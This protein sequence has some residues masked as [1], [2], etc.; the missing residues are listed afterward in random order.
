MRTIRVGFVVIATLWAF[1]GPGILS[2]A[3]P[4]ASAEIDR[5]LDR[6]YR[7]LGIQPAA[8]IPDEVFLRRIYLDVA[9]RIP[10][11]EE[12]RTFL[13][14]T[15]PGKRAQLIDELLESE[16]YVS[17]FFN[18]WADILRINDQV[19]N[20]RL[21]ST[22]WALWVKQALRGNMPY[23]QFVREMVSAE[24]VIWENG[25]VGYYQRDR[26]MPL[27]NMSNTVRIF[28]GTRLECAQ[29]HNHPFDTWKQID[30]YHM[31]AFSYGMNARNYD[32]PNRKA[33]T[34]YQREMARNASAKDKKN[35]NSKNAVKYRAARRVV[36]D[37]YNPIRYIASTQTERK[38][39]LP[40]D[41]QYDDFKPKAVVGPAAMFGEEIDPD[42]FDS[43][44]DAYADWM[45]SPDNPRFTLVIANRL[46]K[47][48][49]GRGLIEPVDELMEGTEAANPAL[50]EFLVR[51]M[52]EVDYDMKAFLRELYNTQIY[53]REASTEELLPGVVYHFPGPVLRRMSA[54]QIWDS[55]MTL[56]IP[57]PDYF[58]PTL[59]NRLA[60]VDQAKKIYENLEGRSREDFLDLVKK[61]TQIY[62]SNYLKTEELSRQYTKAREND[63]ADKVKQIGKEL[64]GLRNN[65]RRK[66][67]QLAGTDNRD[68]R[69][70]PEAL[71]SV[72][73][74]DGSQQI[75]MDEITTALPK[76]EKVQADRSL[77]K[78][79]QKRFYAEL[80]R[81]MAEWRKY[82][83]QLMRASELSSP[84]P[85]GHFV[86]EFGQS[87]REVIENAAYS[88]S[89]P[90]ALT[91]LNGPVAEALSN[92][93]S[94]LSKHL[95]DCGT[96]EEKAQTLYLAMLSRDP[97]REEMELL[98]S[99]I[100][101]HG[102][103]AYENIV[104]ALVNSQNFR[105]I[106]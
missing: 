102:E 106:Q 13:D 12:A 16:G 49:M 92:R 6:S 9:G 4:P 25:A 29:C 54:E 28:L 20:N 59:R 3:T 58:M 57:E 60:Q 32:S 55:L 50:M 7:E 38:V 96:A 62:S 81:D 5:I 105:F 19:N 93:N 34:D 15:E 42:N 82:A 99:E 23:D 65:A 84:A 100:E 27:D 88:A 98:T 11:V 56:T 89:V 48:V 86:R 39:Q 1:Q 87:D 47:R 79:Q 94:V 69:G 41:Y 104:W 8:P 10:T 14:S 24:G 36:T 101:A 70:D 33:V 103:K 76:P 66:L 90:Q 18:Y 52:T 72:F 44:I 74:M 22:A 43:L 37:L 21:P 83:S 78:E 77:S 31:A 51:R 73:G 45:T 35:R 85:R 30:Y 26:G 17:H 71:L 95:A 68:V 75:S 97:D 46:W 91:L 67:T 2:A 64:N 80:G 53:Q 63:E 40:H 61:G